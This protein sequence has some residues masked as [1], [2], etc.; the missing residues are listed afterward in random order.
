ME[1][2]FGVEHGDEVSK[3][4]A[5]L[6][7]KAGL[8]RPPGAVQDLGT[9]SNGARAVSVNQPGTRFLNAKK[10]IKVTQTDGRKFKYKS[11]GGLRNPRKPIYK[12]GGPTYRPDKSF[13]R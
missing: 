6:A 3:S 12:P 9:A 11:G 10:T 13:G 1:S 8:M 4:V 7:R 5:N 2:A